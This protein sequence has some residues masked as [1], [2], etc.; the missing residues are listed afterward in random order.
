MQGVIYIIDTAEFKS[1][2]PVN[3]IFCNAPNICDY[4]GQCLIDHWHVVSC[5]SA[6]FVLHHASLL[7]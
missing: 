6:F 2:L 4:A 5:C 3:L 1:L 7:V